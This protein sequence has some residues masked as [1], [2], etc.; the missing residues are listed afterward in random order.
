MVPP[1]GTAHIADSADP[2]DSGTMPVLRGPRG[3]RKRR[4]ARIP[5]AAR[6]PAAVRALL[7]ALPG[8]AA[9]AALFL[10]AHGVEQAAATEDQPSSAERYAAPRPDIVPRSVWL[11]DAARAQPAPRYDDKVVAVFVHHTDTPNGYDCADVP[12]ILRGVYQGQ[13][14]ARD[15]DDI[16]YNFVVDRCGTVYEGRAGGT[17]RAV[18]GAHTQG[19]NHR[20]TGIAALGTYTA[21]VP[22]PEELTDAIAAVAAWKLGGTGTD[23]RAEVALVSSNGLSRFAAG[24]TATLPAVAGHDDGYATDCPGAAL[25]ARLGDVREAAALLQGRSG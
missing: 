24:A 2:S 22:V 11:G 23:P 1:G 20:T 15:W 3:V 10:C 5:G 18:T 25:A 9:V 17:D 16:G 4:A 8:L 21:G 19:F 14:G 7:G 13:T 6:P 12:A